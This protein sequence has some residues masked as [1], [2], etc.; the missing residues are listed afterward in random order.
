MATAWRQ[1]GRAVAHRGRRRP[2]HRSASVRTS[3]GGRARAGDPKAATA[4]T[5]SGLGADL[6]RRASS[7]GRPKAA[8]AWHGAASAWTSRRPLLRPRSGKP[9][10]APR[11]QRRESSTQICIEE[12]GNPFFHTLSPRMQIASPL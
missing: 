5:W 9:W 3:A 1:R 7:S 11:T 10:A 6:C 4:C 12:R 8:M 2:A